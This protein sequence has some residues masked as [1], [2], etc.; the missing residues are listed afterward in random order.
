[1]RLLVILF[2]FGGF[3][4]FK[5]KAFFY[6]H[7][8]NNPSAQWEQVK[9]QQ[10]NSCCEITDKQWELMKWYFLRV[11]SHLNVTEIVREA[12]FYN[13]SLYMSYFLKDLYKYT[14]LEYYTHIVRYKKK[15]EVADERDPDDNTYQ[16]HAE[17]PKLGNSTYYI[18]EDKLD[19]RAQILMKNWN[20]EDEP[21]SG[22]VVLAKSI[23][24]IDHFLNGKTKQPFESKRSYYI[25][26]IYHQITHD[27]DMYA[28]SILSKLWKVH[29]ILNAIVVGSC[30]KNNVSISLINLKSF[31]FLNFQQIFFSF[32]I[33]I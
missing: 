33:P 2:L 26:L 19:I 23:E 1:M 4:I 6:C 7:L 16:W 10:N 24:T 31:S 28:S 29:G 12:D 22:N 25:I 3:F 21:D 27:W 18:E 5:G 14:G 17:L 15:Q 32:L 8:E 13:Q 20:R 30:K 9:H 11:G